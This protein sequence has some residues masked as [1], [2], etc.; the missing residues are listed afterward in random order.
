MTLL[1]L[2]PDT[3]LTFKKAL[4][5]HRTVQ[6]IKLYLKIVEEYYLV[7]GG[8]APLGMLH[9]IFCSSLSLHLAPHS[10]KLENA[11]P[12]FQHVM[13]SVNDLVAWGSCR[14]RVCPVV[15]QP[16]PDRDEE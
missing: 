4:L 6:I 2:P 7:L 9:L 13:E 15:A 8:C 11:E 3:I 16:A 12:D 1:T 14:P 10:R 5:N